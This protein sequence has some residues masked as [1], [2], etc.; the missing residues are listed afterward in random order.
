MWCPLDGGGNEKEIKAL[1]CPSSVV[2]DRPHIVARV[3]N[4]YNVCV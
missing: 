1:L 2:F 4:R 3:Y